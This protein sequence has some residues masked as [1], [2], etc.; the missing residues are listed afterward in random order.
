MDWW[1]LFRKVRRVIF[2]FIALASLALTVVL[3]LYLS[4]EW[5]R[6][7]IFQR[8]IVVALIG[9]N[10]LT[11]LLLYLMI[12]VVFR[13]WKE[14]LRVLFLLAIHIGTAVPFTLIDFSFPCDIFSSKTTCKIVALTFLSS[15][16]SITGLLLGYT[17]YLCIMSRVPRPFPL[18]TP[19]DLL[20]T[21]PASRAPSVRSVRSVHSSTRLLSLS[22]TY[23]APGSVVRAPSLASVYSQ[24]QASDAS[25]AKTIPKRLFVA[26]SG[27][28][29]PLPA[30]SPS[31]KSL[32]QQIQTY[33]ALDTG[34]IRAPAPSPSPS[35]SPSVLYSRFSTST[36]GSVRSV[37]PPPVLSPPRRLFS[38][39]GAATRPEFVARRPS[40]PARPQRPEER[41]PPRPLLLNLN[42]NVLG[43]DM[44]ERYGTPETARSGV[45][46]TS[47]P[48]N[49][50]V[51]RVPSPSGIMQSQAQGAYGNYL[52]PYSVPPYPQ[53]LP[54]H[55][56]L[57][58][59]PSPQTYLYPCAPQ[60]QL[61]PGYP[62][63]TREPHLLYA[64]V[65]VSTPDRT[66]AGTPGSSSIHSVSPSIH[67]TPAD[68]SGHP[69]VL[70]PGATPPPYTNGNGNGRGA[71]SGRDGW[72][73]LPPTAHLRSTS[74]P[75]FRPY[76]ADPHL[77]HS[78]TRPSD[79]PYDA[80]SLPNPYAGGAEI[81]RY[82]SVPH[83]RVASSGAGGADARWREAVLKAAGAG[84]G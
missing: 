42:P 68:A 29:P 24:D 34:S 78:H 19:N 21:P 14:L 3:S 16:W 9:V 84:R 77:H 32:P 37:S 8:A 43:L 46:Y 59:S 39:R 22:S 58:R 63:P 23:S 80:F 54:Q 67:F 62:H 40:A 41:V 36:L 81:R 6:F 74:D 73:R 57:G 56:P 47:A 33:G 75:L 60:L 35:P 50:G 18:V 52:M 72:T 38:L 31:R 82:G 61:F 48:A 45:S 15:A 17:V 4:K 27:P 51:G 11:S 53:P 76:S 66:H 20:S 71:G 70:T 44:L 83:V 65:P 5:I 49:L 30:D 2:A 13:M 55:G 12:V 25:R 69:A 10:A 1:S 7:S 26:N 79:T 28:A 64:D